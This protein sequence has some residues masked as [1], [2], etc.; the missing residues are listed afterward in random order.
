MSKF[1][2][3]WGWSMLLVYIIFMSVFIFYFWRS[4]KE[5]E[6]NELVTEDYYE[7]ELVYG[8][9]LAKK[10]NADTM[11]IQVQIIKDTD[12]LRIVFPE[13]ISKIEGNIFLYKPDNSKLD[14][15]IPIK[16]DKKFSQKINK[17]QLIPG[18]WD[19]SLDWKING[20]PYFI[21]KKLNL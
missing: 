7:K 3:N 4:F 21:E 8:D 5:L 9:V 20:T 17:E 14:Q 19:I 11:R 1:K 13:Y 2:L 15:T 10:K 6:S 12:G 16:L 18:R